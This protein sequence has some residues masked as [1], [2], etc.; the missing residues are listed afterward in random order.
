MRSN[1]GMATRWRDV[2]V[3]TL[4]WLQTVRIFDIHMSLAD[5]TP[6]ERYTCTIINNF[7]F[8]QRLSTNET[9]TKEIARILSFIKF[10]LVAAFPR[11]VSTSQVD[12]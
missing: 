5:S 6:L 4:A 10:K 7:S 8:S 9:E 11:L 2:A 1:A 12:K 3:R